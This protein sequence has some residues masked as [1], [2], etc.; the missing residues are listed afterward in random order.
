M[1]ALHIPN[2][3][4]YWL[5]M[6]IIIIVVKYLKRRKEVAIVITSTP[7]ESIGLTFLQR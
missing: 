1:D 4:V 3:K 2:L 7:A 6:L 5:S